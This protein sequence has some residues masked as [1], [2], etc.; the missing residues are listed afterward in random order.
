MSVGEVIFKAGE[1]YDG[2]MWD[3]SALI[4]D[5]EKAYEASRSV[6]RFLFHTQYTNK[7]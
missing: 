6:I 4:R 5:Y 1:M 7:S 3:D 2:D